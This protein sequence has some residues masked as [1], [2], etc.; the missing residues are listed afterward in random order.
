MYYGILD[1]VLNYL[2]IPIKHSSHNLD[3]KD[4]PYEGSY[5]FLT[6]ILSQYD[7]PS[8]SW[9]IKNKEQLSNE[10]SPFITS[11]DGKWILVT[12][13]SLP[14]ISYFQEGARLILRDISLSRFINQWDGQG[15]SFDTD[16]TY[17][18]VN[19]PYTNRKINIFKATGIWICLFSVFLGFIYLG[20]FTNGIKPYPLIVTSAIGVFIS[21]LLIQKQLRISNPI[22]E[23]LCN[24][25]PQ[26]H[27]DAVT[28]SNGSSVFGV[29][30]LSE[31]GMGFF[32]TNLIYLILFPDFL[33]WISIAS[34]C[35]LPFS[36]WSI[37]YQ[38][39]RVHSWCPLCLCTLSLMWLQGILCFLFNSF[40]PTRFIFPYAFILLASYLFSTLFSNYIVNLFEDLFRNRFWHR[41][42]NEVISDE[43]VFHTFM[44][45]GDVYPISESEC[46]CLI[47]GDPN[48]THTI[49]IFSNPY[50]GPCAKMHSRIKDLPGKCVKI[51]YVFTSFSS[52]RSIINKAF[53]AAYM[54]LG[55][56]ETWKLLTDWFAGGKSKHMNFFT[57]YN[58]DIDNPFV[59]E[60]FLKQQHWAKVNN[61]HSTPIDFVDGK[62][63]VWPYL[64]EDYIYMPYDRQ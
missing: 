46:S 15:L 57:S 4:I 52:A 51:Q 36:F 20:R 11:F 50:C 16:T 12:N 53:I 26:N 31:V 14:S 25:I 33:C 1:I 10:I 35:V 47:F 17:R 37:W 3:S 24:L 44:G 38:K 30:K 59:S 62:E 49:T 7:I 2:R 42:F 22:A 63:L 28:T 5:Y 55:S 34:L 41:K 19:K 60:E 29:V 61:L 54:Q 45:A 6:S 21:Y 23:K 13:I 43:K 56:E 39:F 8:C 32:T 27:C 48:A 58:L 40:T 64:P 9:K 18:K